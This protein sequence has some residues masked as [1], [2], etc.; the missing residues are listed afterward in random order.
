MS[1][2]VRIKF[3]GFKLS[4]LGPF[5][6]IAWGDSHP[7]I[8]VVASPPPPHITHS[9]HEHHMFPFIWECSLVLSGDVREFYWR[10]TPNRKCEHKSLQLQAELWTWLCWKPARLD[11]KFSSLATILSLSPATKKLHTPLLSW[12]LL[13]P[14]SPLYFVSGF[15]EYLFLSTS[16]VRFK[17]C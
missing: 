10:I 15:P 2:T 9:N 6:I 11:T 16:R 14:V 7:H 4:S 1:S 12:D 3:C 17:I 5:T 13:P 8:F